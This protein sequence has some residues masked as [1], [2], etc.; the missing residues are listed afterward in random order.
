MAD[1]A[2]HVVV[3]Q[4]TNLPHLTLFALRNPLSNT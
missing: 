1:S 2:R 3:A 4:L